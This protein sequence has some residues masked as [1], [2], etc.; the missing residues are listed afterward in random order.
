MGKIPHF[1]GCLASYKTVLWPI[2]A[3]KFKKSG[4]SLLLNE[5]PRGWKV[6]FNP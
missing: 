6:L 1:G 2:A 4:T 5:L 3:A